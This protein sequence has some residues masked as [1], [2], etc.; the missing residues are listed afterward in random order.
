MLLALSV[1]DK[2]QTSF[3]SSSSSFHCLSNTHIHTHKLISFV[4]KR[5]NVVLMTESSVIHERCRFFVCVCV[6]IF[7]FSHRM[8]N[9]PKCTEFYH[10]HLICIKYWVSMELIFCFFLSFCTSI[11]IIS[12]ILI[13]SIIIEA[14]RS[15]EC[16]RLKSDWM[17]M[18]CNLHSHHC[19]DFFFFRW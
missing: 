16:E 14:K 8:L 19:L 11:W 6:C 4:I 15:I 17:K 10:F 2:Y 7:N 12:I 5:Q 9:Y 3:F 1:S 13:K 18:N